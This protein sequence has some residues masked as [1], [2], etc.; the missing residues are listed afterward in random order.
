MSLSLSGGISAG[1]V[2]N[3]AIGVGMGVAS[4]ATGRVPASIRCLNP[5][6]LVLFDFNPEKLE[7]KRTANITHQPAAGGS[8]GS[9]TGASGSIAQ[10]V[11]APTITINNIMFEGALTKATCD[12]LLKWMSPPDSGGVPTSVGDAIGSAMNQLTA[13]PQ[14]NPALVTF[15]WGP[16]LI[17]FMYDVMISNCSISYTRFTPTGIPIRALVSLTMEQQP[18]ALSN[19]PTNPTSG[20]RPGRR[21]HVIKAGDTLH[22]IATMY[23][24]RPGLWRRVAE[25]NRLVNPAQLRPGRVVYLPNMDELT[26]TAR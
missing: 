12:T 18:N 4:L 5:F 8:V 23:Y 24:G 6:G 11:K 9:P 17:G 25:V 21:T 14:S 2:A 7:V 1:G 26:E 20:G 13:V 16:P 10:Q 19:L 22:S 15:Q 3:A